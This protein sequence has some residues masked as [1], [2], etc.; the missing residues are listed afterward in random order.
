MDNPRG[1]YRVLAGASGGCD[2]GGR[3]MNP[4]SFMLLARETERKPFG[5]GVVW[6]PQEADQTMARP[7]CVA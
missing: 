7:C 3:K 4:A 1:S 6:N 5:A 2:E